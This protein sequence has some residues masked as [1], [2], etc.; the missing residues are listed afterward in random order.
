MTAHPSTR[1]L[2]TGGVVYVHTSTTAYSA[3]PTCST[4]AIA[5][6]NVPV[7]IGRWL[8]WC[9]FTVLSRPV[10]K[11][12][13]AALL[14]RVQE[15]PMH[16]TRIRID[17]F[18]FSIFRRARAHMKATYRWNA[19]TIAAEGMQQYTRKP[20]RYLSPWQPDASV[21]QNADALL[22]NGTGSG[23]MKV[24]GYGTIAADFSSECA[25]WLEFDSPDL[26]KYLASGAV[27][28]LMYVCS[29]HSLILTHSAPFSRSC[30]CPRMH[31]EPVSIV[32][33]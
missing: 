15:I 30:L 32:C 7:V 33:Y 18:P 1:D 2:F 6:T 17:I 29:N 8:H 31:N 3:C 26:G 14:T 13:A 4:A 16:P 12:I 11:C 22:T 10:G 27:S 28:V 5:S 21:F 9:S 24:V 20:V 19:K 23:V 25:G